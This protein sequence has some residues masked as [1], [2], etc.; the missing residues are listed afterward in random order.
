[1]FFLF[2]SFFFFFSP[3]GS[4]LVGKLGR[5]WG[6]VHHKWCGMD[7]S[8]SE[9]GSVADFFEHGNEPSDSIKAIPVTGSGGL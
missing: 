6:T 4:D 7:V 9:W 1:V 8:D 3:E 2:F 5:G